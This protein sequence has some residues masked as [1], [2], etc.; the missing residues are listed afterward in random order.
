MAHEVHQ[1]T[2]RPEENEGS[3]GLFA[4]PWVLPEVEE[5]NGDEQATKHPIVQ[6]IDEHSFERHCRFTEHMDEQSLEFSFSKMND[7]H[8]E[9]CQLC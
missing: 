7:N 2:D 5:L 6:G 1:F 3:G 9:Q 8:P 4:V